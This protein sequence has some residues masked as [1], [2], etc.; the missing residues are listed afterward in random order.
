MKTLEAWKG[1]NELIVAVILFDASLHRSLDI[2]SQEAR[3]G[4]DEGAITFIEGRGL[5]DKFDAERVPCPI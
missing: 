5:L 3:Y 1:S 2:S 4:E